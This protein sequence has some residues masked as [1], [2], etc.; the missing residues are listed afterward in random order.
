MSVRRKTTNR[1]TLYRTCHTCGRVFRTTADNPFMRQ[2]YNVDGKKQKTCYFC[3]EGCW[4]ASYKHTGYWD[5]LTEA[6]KK[7]KEAARDVREKNRRY[8]A[9]HAEKERQ[10]ARERYWRDP[11]VAREDNRYQRKKRRLQNERNTEICG[12]QAG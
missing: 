9:A 1:L 5:G 3:S 10:R 12:A 11:K 6:R 8:Y 4:R 2:M 7:A